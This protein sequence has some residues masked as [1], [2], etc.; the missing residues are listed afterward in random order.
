MKTLRL[1]LRVFFYHSYQ[2]SDNHV[3]NLIL[4]KNENCF[5]ILNLLLPP[6]AHFLP[7]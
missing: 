7:L 4:N 3:R 5:S 1:V 6:P 2:K